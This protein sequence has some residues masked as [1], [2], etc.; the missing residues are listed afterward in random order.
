MS[1]K[2]LIIKGSGRSKGY[3]NMLCHELVDFLK[4]QEVEV[5]DTYNANIIPCNGCD[6]CRCSGVCINRDLDGFYK[7]FEECDVVIFLSP[8]YNGTFSAP[9][10]SLIDRFQVY[11]TSFYENGKIQPI[12]KKRV[13]YLVGAAGRAGNVAFGYMESQ[14][15]CAFTILNM[16]L[17]ASF[18]CSNT[19]TEPN[20]DIVLNQMKRSL[21]END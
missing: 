7:S 14:L 4:D 11:Y 13:A 1:K 3:T 18:L 19:D 10:K 12:R 6:Y 8:I 16:E 20:F 9:L 15:K 21:S 5:F 17:K 2:Y